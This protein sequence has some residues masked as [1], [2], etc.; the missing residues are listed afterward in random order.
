MLII[1]LGTVQIFYVLVMTDITMMEV[2]EHVQNVI[3]VVVNAHKQA[4]FVRLVFYLHLE[5]N[6]LIIRVHAMQDIM[7]MVLILYAKI[8]IIHV[9][10]VKIQQLNVLDVNLIQIE[11]YRITIVIVIPTIIM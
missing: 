10:L 6:K 9:I 2:M 4:K 11:H 5:R 7:M 3:I 1:G 8:V